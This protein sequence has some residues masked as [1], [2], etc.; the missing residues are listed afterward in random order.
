MCRA[1]EESIDVR[2]ILLEEEKQGSNILVH[3]FFTYYTTVA[4][5][6]MSFFMEVLSLQGYCIL[7]FF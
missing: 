3:I 1:L 4:G 7:Q 5:I 2:I 6:Q